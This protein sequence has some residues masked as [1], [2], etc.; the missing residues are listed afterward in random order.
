MD[1][2]DN[3][4]DY[5]TV[6]VDSL[7]QASKN[8][9]S[10]YLTEPMK[11]VVQAKLLATHIHSADSVQHLY[12]SINELNSIFNDRATEDL[13]GQGAISRVR[14]AFAS[15]ALSSDHTGAS[16]QVINF[17]EK[18]YYEISN[19]YP[20]IIR[21]VDRLT[22]SLLDE[23]GNTIPNPAVGTDENMFILRFK[24]L[25]PSVILP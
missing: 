20:S 17:R 7:D 4:Y 18:S 14:G 2:P 23:S 19:E 8:T 12:I 1:L 21:R 24:C 9:F 13:N 3:K 6:T 11:N 25:S 16:D 22:V 15:V 10:V 5:Y